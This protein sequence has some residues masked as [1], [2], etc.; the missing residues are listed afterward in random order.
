M[1]N[2]NNVDISCPNCGTAIDVDE[3]L[4]HQL[5]SDIKKQY[6]TKMIEVEKN[7]EE[8]ED[9]LK[10]YQE[11]L[12]QRAKEIEDKV[13]EQVKTSLKKEKEALQTSIKKDLEEQNAERYK[14]LQKEL[15]EKSAQVVELNK[16]KAE[17]E[18]LK[19][20]K[21]NLRA[22]IELESQKALNEQLAEERTKMSKTLAEKSELKISEK[23]KIIDQ[24]KEQLN[25]AQRKAEQGSMQLQGEVQELG[26]EEWLSGQFPLDDIEEIK[27]GARGGDC[28]QHVNTPH[29]RNCG[30]IYYESKRTKDFS[31]TWIEKFKNDIRDRGAHIGVLVTA[32]MPKDMDRLG[33]VDGIWICTYNEFKGLCSVLRQNIIQLHMA[34]A[35]QDNKGDKVNILYD[36]LTS[37]EFKLQ[38]EGIVDGWSQMKSDLDSEKRSIQG[39]WKKR[40]KQIEKVLLNTSQM[41]HSIRGIAGNSIERIDTLE[42]PEGDE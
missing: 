39:L 21:N 24:L 12:V 2:K 5:E 37:N 41:Y 20:E 10:K 3:I 4:Y 19:R 38:I 33:F 35:S 25:E 8:K 31:K 18:K 7:F 29:F 42:L 6:Q 27:K 34:V 16:T 36:Y 23:E 30:M 11:T 17:I 22:E 26:I 32:T 13:Q 14:T 28:I 9:K 15:N 40:E 1:N